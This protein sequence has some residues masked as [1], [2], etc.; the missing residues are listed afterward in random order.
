MIA[1]SNNAV[2]KRIISALTVRLPRGLDINIVVQWL[3][4][5]GQ[6]AVIYCYYPSGMLAFKLPPLIQTTVSNDIKVTNE[7]SLLVGYFQF[8]IYDLCF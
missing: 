2:E 8:E 3:E 7:I 4:C 1:F 5:S 6:K